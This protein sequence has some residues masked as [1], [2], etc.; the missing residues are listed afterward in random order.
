[1]CSIIF[2]PLLQRNIHL[3]VNTSSRRTPGL[4]EYALENEKF[5]FSIKIIQFCQPLI[6]LLI[7]QQRVFI[8]SSLC[9]FHLCCTKK[10]SNTE[11][12]NCSWQLL[13]NNANRLINIASLWRDIKIPV[14]CPSQFRGQSQNITW[15]KRVLPL[16]TLLI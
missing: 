13:N 15:I 10:A 1:M 11:R 3:I 12:Q 7:L 4:L 6:M 9:S 2:F 16:A 5:C 14:K 8:S